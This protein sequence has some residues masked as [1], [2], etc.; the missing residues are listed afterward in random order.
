LPQA[1]RQVGL[2]RSSVYAI[3]P[4]KPPTNRKLDT[5]QPT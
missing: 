3:P 4:R 1:V 2:V 5:A